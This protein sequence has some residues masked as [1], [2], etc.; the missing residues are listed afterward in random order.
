[1][2]GDQNMKRKRGRD[3]KEA[4]ERPS[5]A[6]VT[7]GASK[8]RHHLG[9]DDDPDEKLEAVQRGEQKRSGDDVPKPLRGKGRS[10]DPRT[11]MGSDGGS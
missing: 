4:G 5:A 11:G 9:R 2:E 8:Q 6:G 3:A 1:M 7:G 10:R